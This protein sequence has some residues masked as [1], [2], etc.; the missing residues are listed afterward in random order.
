MEMSGNV[1]EQ[2]I[3]TVTTTAT[4]NPSPYT[5]EWGDGNLTNGV[6]DVTNWPTSGFFTRKGGSFVDTKDRARISDR[7]ERGETN[8]TSRPYNNGGR[9]CR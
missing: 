3:S 5:G 1:W 2:C 4:G 6:Y 8:Y 9:G 7:L